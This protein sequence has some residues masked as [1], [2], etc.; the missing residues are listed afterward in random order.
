MPKWRK[1]NVFIHLLATNL[2]IGRNRNAAE[3]GGPVHVQTN[4]SI[5]CGYLQR[6]NFFVNR[7]DP[8][9]KEVALH[10]DLTVLQH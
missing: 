3:W 9:V 8:G 1:W 5:F 7:V 2:P 4:P 6:L 10:E